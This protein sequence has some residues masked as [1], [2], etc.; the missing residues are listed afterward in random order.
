M[1]TIKITK[2]FAVS[3]EMYDLYQQ[4]EKLEVGLGLRLLLNEPHDDEMV[5]QVHPYYE[6]MLREAL[7]D[8]HDTYE[9]YGFWERVYNQL[10]NLT[11]END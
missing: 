3:D 2:E 6:G 9:G 11:S 1:K 7:S 10:D 5:R 4:L 8:W